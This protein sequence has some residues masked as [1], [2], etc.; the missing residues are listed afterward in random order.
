MKE[1]LLSVTAVAEVF[2]DGQKIT[3]AV[4]EFDRDIDNEKLS[5]A[6][7]SVK[8]RT[9]TKIYANIEPARADKGKNG[10]Y[11]IIELSLEDAEAQ[12]VPKHSGPR[13]GGPD[14][15]GGHGRP[16]SPGGPGGQRGQFPR[17][18]PRVRKPLKL[19]I[20]QLDVIAAAD[21][22]LLPA[23]RNDIVS[24]KTSQPI[25]DDFRQY[26]YK[27]LQYN[28]FVPRDYDRKGLYPLV[29]FMS[30]ASTN[31]DDALLPLVQGIGGVIWA[32]PEEQ[33]KHPCF[34]LVPQIPHGV[35]LMRD[36]FNVSPELETIKELLDEVV[37]RYNI[38]ENCIYTT[39]QSQ[40]CMVSC[41]L[42]VRYP[43]YFA[44][45]LLVSG[46]WNPETMA[47]KLT[48][49]NLFIALSEGGPREFPGMNAVTAALEAAGAKVA[50][51]YLNARKSKAELNTDVKELIATG[52]NILYAIYDA[53]M[54]LPDDGKEYSMMAHHSRGWEITYGIEAV[55][56]WLLSQVRR[57]P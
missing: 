34:V 2:P 15:P 51:A 50:R 14:D 28:L 41:E 21:G 3:A 20:K 10:K 45:S 4:V 47:A 19:S 38:D 48:Q 8:D 18:P 24:N 22:T 40:G 44:A 26:E 11:V 46:Q 7:F 35:P 17:M 16:G 49:K 13:P 52:A 1:Y 5:P 30:D 43:D 12:I 29:M 27:G 33:A 42:N 54:A 39:G 53:K 23:S 56:D 36:N 9:I 6:L 31:S 57:Q 37:S 25:V 32:T 55:R